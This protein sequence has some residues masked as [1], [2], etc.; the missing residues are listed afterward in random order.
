MKVLDINISITTESIRLTTDPEVLEKYIGIKNMGVTTMLVD[1]I[2]EMGYVLHSSPTG[3]VCR[4]KEPLPDN[5]KAYL[6][7]CG[8]PMKKER[9]IRLTHK[10]F[11]SSQPKAKEL[12][13]DWKERQENKIWS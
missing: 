8:L 4:S 5:I 11:E 7:L 2:P 6:I 10:D 12:M 1:S 13:D 3:I 9:L